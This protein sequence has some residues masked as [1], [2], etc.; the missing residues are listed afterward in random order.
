[1]DPQQRMALETAYHAFE[2]V[3]TILVYKE[4]VA[5]RQCTC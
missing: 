3:S 5:I 1:M 2:T 4:K